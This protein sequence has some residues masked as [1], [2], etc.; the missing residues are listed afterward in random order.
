MASGSFCILPPT[1]AWRAAT[2]ARQGLLARAGAAAT[3]LRR[4]SAPAVAL[5]A[6]DAVVKRCSHAEAVRDG[7]ARP[8]A[9]PPAR[10][11]AARRRR[12]AQPRLRAATIA[13]AGRGGGARR[14]V[15]LACGRPRARCAAAK[16]AHLLS[17]TSTRR[18]QPPIGRA[19]SARELLTLDDAVRQASRFFFECRPRGVP[20]R[21]V[22]PCRTLALTPGRAGGGAR[23]AS[24]DQP[25]G[26]S[27]CATVAAARAR[28]VDARG[29]TRRRA[30][31]VVLAG[32]GRGAVPSWSKRLRAV[33]SA[34]SPSA[35]P[36]PRAPPPRAP[37]SAVAL[38]LRR[39]LLRCVAHA[40]DARPPRP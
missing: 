16:D 38:A 8:R 27:A 15:T 28:V 37:R 13:L 6:G 18:S 39:D 9:C 4:P 24:R 34:A 20:A 5:Y 36:P 2:A 30:P 10:A 7:R 33:D 29:A 23:L 12:S 21:A 25:G 19:A 32:G 40:T 17:R 35:S 14:V 22:G 3:R 26:G 11:L 1:S 31:A